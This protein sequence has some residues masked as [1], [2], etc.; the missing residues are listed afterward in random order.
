MNQHQNMRLIKSIKSQV[1]RILVPIAAL[2]VLVPQAQAVSCCKNV[3]IYCEPTQ[4]LMTNCGTR[5]VFGDCT[6]PDSFARRT[7]G[8]VTGQTGVTFYMAQ[9]NYTCIYIDCNGDPESENVHQEFQE[10][11][12]SGA[13]C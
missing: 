6:S 5:A 13:A 7:C 1:A 4:I 2:A 9:C 12:A 3:I 11:V 10:V 8:Q